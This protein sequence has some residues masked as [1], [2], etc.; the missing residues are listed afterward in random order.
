ML[1]KFGKV[2]RKIR[3][4]RDELLGDMAKNIGVSNAFLSKIE[5]GLAKPSDKV[6]NNIIE[7]YELSPTERREL[8]E[9]A[10]EQKN[11]Y[12]LNFSNLSAEEKKLTIRF[13]KAISTL[14]DDDRSIIEDILDRG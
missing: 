8:E 1:S 6:I 11:G 13:A 7:K 12:L 9:A 5:N 4:E 10:Y 2:T 14:N 3:I